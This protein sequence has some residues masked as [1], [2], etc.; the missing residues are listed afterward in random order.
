LY[1]FFITFCVADI[2]GEMEV[3]M[4]IGYHEDDLLYLSGIQHMAF[5]ERQW[6]LIHIEQA[7]AENIRTV[8]GKHLHERT[9]DPFL[10]ETRK[11]IRVVRAMPI[12]SY[13]LGLR[14]IADVVEFHRIKKFIEGVTVRL[15]KRS[16]WWRVY[17]VEY[18]RGR[19]KTDDRDVVQLCAQA[20]ALEEMLKIKID[21]GFLYYGQ[22]RRRIEIALNSLVR[23]R[24]KDLTER[25]H[26]MFA[27]GKT[28]IAQKGKR[29]SLC[30][31]IEICQP[32]L[33]LRHKSVAKYLTR[34]IDC[35][36]TDH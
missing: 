30:S 32:N 36:V 2:C 18:K 23:D 29:C 28:P 13:E 31:L 12:I 1:S 15:E 21:Q 9:D 17:P 6:A 20:M 34:M 11:D 35:E 26:K 16:G 27:E 14:G 25:M 5:C 8:E 10:N 4:V 19:P 24:V 3:N 33:T 7:W 22:T